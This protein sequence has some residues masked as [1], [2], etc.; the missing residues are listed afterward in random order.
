M[1]GQRPLECPSS[2]AQPHPYS[3]AIL[4]T[5]VVDVVVDVDVIG[6]DLLRILVGVCVYFPAVLVGVLRWLLLLPLFF[7]NITFFLLVL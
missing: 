2:D 3:F 5:L 7:Y 6:L 4:E 1:S